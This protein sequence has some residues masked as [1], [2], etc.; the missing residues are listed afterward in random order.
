MRTFDLVVAK[1]PTNARGPRGPHQVLFMPAGQ[2]RGGPVIPRN[3]SV[4]SELRFDLDLLGLA[5]G[6]IDQI[7]GL[8]DGEY[9][10][11]SGL[12]LD[13]RQCLTFGL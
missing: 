1:F 12:G 6:R 13:E 10:S 5:S 2:H 9:S 7:V 3:Y 8:G 4:E 11:L